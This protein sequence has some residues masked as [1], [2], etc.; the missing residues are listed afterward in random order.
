MVFHWFQCQAWVLSDIGMQKSKEKIKQTKKILLSSLDFT[1][2]S[3]EWFHLI[4]LPWNISVTHRILMSL[5]RDLKVDSHQHVA[6]SW[7]RLLPRG[8]CYSAAAILCLSPGFPEF[9]LDGTYTYLLCHTCRLFSGQREF[10]L[11]SFQKSTLMNHREVSAFI[12]NSQQR[13]RGEVQCSWCVLDVRR[14]H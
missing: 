3:G 4:L 13:K 5:T 2:S 8:Q 11:R 10:S 1:W 7:L 6:L 12:L 9:F 14:Q